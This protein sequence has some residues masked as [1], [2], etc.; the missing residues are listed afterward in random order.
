MGRNIRHVYQYEL[1]IY[2]GPATQR[3]LPVT[4]T[5]ILY[6]FIDIYEIIYMYSCLK[7]VYTFNGQQLFAPYS[8]PDGSASVRFLI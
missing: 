4:E 2:S 7:A 3:K 5:D 8:V 1:V 6:P